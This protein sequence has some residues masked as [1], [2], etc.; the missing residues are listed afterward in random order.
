VSKFIKIRLQDFVVCF[1]SHPFRKELIRHLATPSSTSSTT[2][3]RPNEA[4]EDICSSANEE[5][6]NSSDEDDISFE[7]L[8]KFINQPMTADEA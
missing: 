8:S 6:F 5:E 2:V 7:E 3:Q 1:Q 4:S